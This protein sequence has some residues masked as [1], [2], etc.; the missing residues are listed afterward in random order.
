MGNA[1]PLFSIGASSGIVTTARELDYE[2]T[3]QHV[4]TVTVSDGELSDTATVTVNVTDVHEGPPNGYEP[5]TDDDGSIFEADIEWL[6]WE[7]ITKGCNPPDND[8]FCP[9]DYVA[10]GQM[11]AFLVR[12]LGYTDDGGGDLFVDDDDSIF[13]ADI[14]RLGAAG[15][16]K[17]CNP[18]DNDR[19]CPAT[20]VTR[21]QMAA[22]LHRA[23]GTD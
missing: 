2:T 17:G 21:A 19:Y 5:F 15:V 9:N 16:T 12:A 1:G 4:L 6:A 11:A 8:M 22:F 3:T 7:G 13:E 14:D 23:L 10:R 18:P 20:Y